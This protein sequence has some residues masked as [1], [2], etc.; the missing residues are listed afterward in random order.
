M[1]VKMVRAV[2]ADSNRTYYPLHQNF[3]SPNSEIFVQKL[4]YLVDDSKLFS[5]LGISFSTTIIYT[6]FEVKERG[7]ECGR[8]GKIRK[9]FFTI[10]FG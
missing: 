7:P 2:L 8:A 5:H 3:K 9:K 1:V 6:S 10:S 4:H